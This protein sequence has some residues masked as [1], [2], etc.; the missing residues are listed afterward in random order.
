MQFN[1]GI[2]WPE[3]QATIQNL[4]DFTENAKNLLGLTKE[5]FLNVRAEKL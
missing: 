1:T 3:I 5:N 4:S 2:L